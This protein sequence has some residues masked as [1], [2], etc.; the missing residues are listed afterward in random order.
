M[1]II[2]TKHAED[3]HTTLEGLLLDILQDRPERTIQ[4]GIP[5]G[6]S[7]T[8]L[9]TALARLE[10]ELLSRIRLILVDE[11]LEGQTNRDTLLDSGLQS[12]I[13]EG[14]FDKTQLVDTR[15]YDGSAFD[16]VF[17]GVGEDG[18]VASLFPPVRYSQEPPTSIIEDS[19]KPP[20]RRVTITY[21]G[22]L[23]ESSQALY[24]LLFIGKAKREALER[25]RG[26]Q[27]EEIPAGFFASRFSRCIVITD[28]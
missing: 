26:P 14:L 22:F 10:R 5:G 4:I 12:L 8:Y 3:L 23:Q 19:P 11:R 1:R 17:L 13:E 18:H 9:I 2:H 21:S 7:A 28:E 16:A 25:L 6:R 27:K 20:P 15:D 24:V